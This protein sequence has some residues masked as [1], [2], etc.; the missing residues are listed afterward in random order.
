MEPCLQIFEKTWGTKDAFIIN[1]ALA[2]NG[3]TN[4]KPIP[5]N[6]YPAALHSKKISLEEAGLDSKHSSFVTQLSK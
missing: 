3:I 1:E 2:A 6:N 5:L 4:L